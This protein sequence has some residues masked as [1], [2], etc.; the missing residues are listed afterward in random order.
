M[1]AFG[2]D[3]LDFG[4]LCLGNFRLSNLGLGDRR[5]RHN[6]DWARG[7]GTFC[8]FHGAAIGYGVERIQRGN[9][10]RLGFGVMGEFGGR[11]GLLRRCIKG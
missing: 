2:R 6:G 4:G 5:F 1:R 3:R 11:L 7:D 9:L 8:R 10:L